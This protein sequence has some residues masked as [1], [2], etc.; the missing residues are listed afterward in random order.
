LENHLFTFTIGCETFIHR[1]VRAVVE[2]ACSINVSLISIEKCL[3]IFFFNFMQLTLG[4][5]GA[6]SYVPAGLTK[7]QYEKL[8]KEEVAKKE[9]NYK[10]NVAKA[11]KFQDY[12]EFYKKRGTDIKESWIKSVTRGHTMAK[13]KY[14]WSGEKKDKNFAA[15]GKPPTK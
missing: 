13:T 9:A 2:K 8:R 7:E 3:V 11:G 4:K 5:I 1:D 10:R 6:N 14:D 12:T 15:W